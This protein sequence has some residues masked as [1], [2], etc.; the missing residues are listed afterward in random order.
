MKNNPRYALL[1]LTL[2]LALSLPLTTQADTL[3]VNTQNEFNALPTDIELAIRR[4][5]P[6]NVTVVLIH[7]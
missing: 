3:R 2:A 5:A 7:C 4:G 1:T 6:D